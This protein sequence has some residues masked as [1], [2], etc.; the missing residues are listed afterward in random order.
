M[1]PH[2]LVSLRSTPLRV[3]SQTGAAQLARCFA[4]IALK[5]CSLNPRFTFDA[6]R[7][8]RGNSPLSRTT[9]IEALFPLDDAEGCRGEREYAR[10][11]LSEQGERVYVEPRLSQT[12]RVSA[13]ADE[14][15][16]ALLHC[17]RPS[18]A[19][20]VLTRP[21]CRASFLVATRK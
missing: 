16:G 5:Q 8:R 14:P 12:P 20:A 13:L 6:R 15:V 19:F 21:M 10:L 1:T 17:S 11:C 4:L 9:L 7:R 3:S 18:M 2:D